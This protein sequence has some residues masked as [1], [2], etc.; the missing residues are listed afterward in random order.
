MYYLHLSF[1][2]L[3]PPSIYRVSVVVASW[4]DLHMNLAEGFIAGA[5][6]SHPFRDVS[7]RS[8][9]DI[10]NVDITGGV[11]VTSLVTAV[12]DGA[13]GRALGGRDGVRKRHATEPWSQ[14]GARSINHVGKS[15]LAYHSG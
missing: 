11:V 13:L 7:V 12:V 15:I 14:Y 10:L 9:S 6:T 4:L 1:I 3:D 5:R 2:E 8:T